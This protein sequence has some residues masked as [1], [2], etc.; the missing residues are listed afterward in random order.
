MT[1]ID[2]LQARRRIMPYLRRTPMVDSPW[3][4]DLA[5][6]RVSLKLESLQL[7]SSFKA[8]GAF[9]NLLSRRAPEAGV[10]A[11][12]GGNHG[13]AVAYAAQ[14]LGVKARIFVP[15]ISSPAKVDAIRLYGM[16]AVWKTVG[17][18]LLDDTCAQRTGRH[19]EDGCWPAF[20]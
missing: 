19:E 8:R 11:A 13:A 18:R 3:L 6:A 20:D 9:H 12:S 4:S 1:L 16:Q 7:S 10:A 5:G 17:Q 2:V 15:E 14:R